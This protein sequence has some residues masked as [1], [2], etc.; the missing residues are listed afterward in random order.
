MPMYSFGFYS[1]KQQKALPLPPGL[2]GVSL[3]GCSKVFHLLGFT[4]SLE[5]ISGTH[6]CNKL[7]R[8]DVQSSKKRKRKGM[9]TSWE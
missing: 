8:E 1:V 3:R 7:E 6:L 9:K 4:F 5:R 2:D